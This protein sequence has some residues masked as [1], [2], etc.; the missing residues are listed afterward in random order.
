VLGLA[1]NEF[2]DQ[3]HH[4]LTGS[5]VTYAGREGPTLAPNAGSART[6]AST[7]ARPA[8]AAKAAFASLAGAFLTLA[9][10]ASGR[11]SV[12]GGRRILGSA[13]GEDVRGHLAVRIPK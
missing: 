13:I 11:R 9:Q 1:A 8:P 10:A 7:T 12:I 4:L 6:I 3:W 2:F 5:D